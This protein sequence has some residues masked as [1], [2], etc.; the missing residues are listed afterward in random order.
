M[1]A[2]GLSGFVGYFGCS[3]IAAIVMRSDRGDLNHREVSIAPWNRLTM[4]RVWGIM[5][6]LPTASPM[7]KLTA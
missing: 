4:A 2:W 3:E 5:R 1:T 7:L 6:D